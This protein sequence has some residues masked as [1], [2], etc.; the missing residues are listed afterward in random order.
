MSSDKIMCSH[1]LV[2]RFD[3]HEDGAISWSVEPDEAIESTR[4]ASLD[5]LVKAGAPLA[6]LGIRALAALL[7]PCLIETALNTGNMHL[8]KDS[9]LR[10]HEQ[11]SS[12]SPA[13]D[14]ELAGDE[15]VVIH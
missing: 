2:V 14:G 15:A 4:H 11:F 6:A 5:E 8:W 13:I 10:L 12:D 9:C 1:E 3:Q 7:H